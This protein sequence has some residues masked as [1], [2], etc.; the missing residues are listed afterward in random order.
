MNCKDSSIDSSYIE[1]SIFYSRLLCVCL[2]S[3]LFKAVCRSG[4][5]DMPAIARESALLAI[6]LGLRAVIRAVVAKAQWRQGNG[7]R[8]LHCP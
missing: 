7:S 4:A 6:G 5:F 8:S 2:R 1:M 3:F